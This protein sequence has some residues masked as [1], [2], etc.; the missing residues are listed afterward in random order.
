MQ[1]QPTHCNQGLLSVHL[2]AHTWF[3]YLYICTYV[4][5]GA[6]EPP[7]RGATPL[8]VES[9]ALHYIYMYI[10]MCSHPRVALCF[11]QRDLWFTQP[12]CYLILYSNVLNQL[13]TAHDGCGWQYWKGRGRSYSMSDWKCACA[14]PLLCYCVL[15]VRVGESVCARMRVRARVYPVL[16]GKGELQACISKLL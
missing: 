15:L 3:T 13:S 14:Y 6:L 9:L 5:V 2:I 1:V 4:L 7:F 16:Q 12:S 11:Y 8:L 10:G